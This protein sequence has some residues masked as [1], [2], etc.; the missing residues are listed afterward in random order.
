[1]GRGMDALLAVFTALGGLALFLYGMG[2]LS[3]GLQGAAGPGFGRILR[4]T[5][6]SR[7]RAL[8]AGTA[9]GVVLQSSATTLLLVGFAHAGLLRAAAAVPVLLGANVGTTLALQLLSLKAG[10]FALALVAVGLALGAWRRRRPRTAAAG[11]ALF[12]FGLLFLGLNAMGGAVAPYREA[13]APWIARIDGRTPG[14]LLAGFAV[15]LAVTGIVQSSSATL[16]MAFALAAGG[17]LTRF[18]QVYPVILGANL[19][20]CATGLLG[21]I[22][23]GPEGRRVA[24]AHLLFNAFAAV[25]GLAL[26]PVFYRLAPHLGAGLIR[27]AANANTLKMAVTALAALPACRVLARGAASM[28]P[29]RGETA[30]PTHLDEAALARPEDALAATIREVRRAVGLCERSHALAAGLLRHPDRRAAGRIARNEQAVNYVKTSVRAYLR[31]LAGRYL[32]RRQAALLTVLDRA[33][34]DVERVHDHVVVTAR[35]AVQRPRERA[36]RFLEQ[37]LAA[38]ERLQGEAGGILA[39]LGSALEGSPGRASFRAAGEAVR[40][41]AER[42]AASVAVAAGEVAHR[43]GEHAYLPEGGL[44]AAEFAAALDSIARHAAGIARD[45]CLD[46][47]RLKRSK[48]GVASGAAPP[49]LPPV[50]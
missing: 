31:R 7:A 11:E 9:L 13:L 1:M 42:F 35:L 37:D 47:F 44:F 40:G 2:V 29:A 41:R 20:T 34:A 23:S 48:L 26:A 25:T 45:L 19:G 46:E 39:A 8:L 5:V 12:G 6:V 14:G 22:G 30:E 16:G 49:F 33:A 43:V 32:S 21:G 27:Q 18:E 38:L 50:E 17:A 24:Y 3:R 28:S 15:S 4:W 10:R 36:V